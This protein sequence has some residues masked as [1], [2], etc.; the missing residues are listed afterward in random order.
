MSAFDFAANIPSV[1]E[2][3]AKSSIVRNTK[4]N[5]EFLEIQNALENM[6]NKIIAVTDVQ[7]PADDGTYTFIIEKSG[8]LKKHYAKVCARFYKAMQDK[9]WTL[10]I[11]EEEYGTLI[12]KTKLKITFGRTK[13]PPSPPK[14]RASDTSGS[15]SSSDRRRKSKPPLPSPSPL[16]EIS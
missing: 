8:N 3:V 14:T 9:G 16:S 1:E 2:A 15:S 10:C 13:A 12:K 7:E 4:R 11:K 5:Q 6:T